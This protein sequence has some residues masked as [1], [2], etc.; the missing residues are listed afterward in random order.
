MAALVP[1]GTILRRNNAGV[2]VA[3]RT[4]FHY[5]TLKPLE[6]MALLIVSTK[7]FNDLTID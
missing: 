3:L 5:R 7:R 2:N 6:T 4:P 1:C